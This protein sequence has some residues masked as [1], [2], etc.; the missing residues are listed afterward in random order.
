[1]TFPNI[2]HLPILRDHSHF[3][4]TVPS[5]TSPM[6]HATYGL[7]FGQFCVEVLAHGP[8]VANLFL[9]LHSSHLIRTSLFYAVAPNRNKDAHDRSNNCIMANRVLSSSS[10]TRSRCTLCRNIIW[11]DT[12]PSSCSSASLGLFLVAR[13]HRSGAGRLVAVTVSLWRW[14]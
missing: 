4:F 14:I 13:L 7:R 11:K 12:I 9:L 5:G 10:T 8:Q 2:T 1:M 3:E 6:L